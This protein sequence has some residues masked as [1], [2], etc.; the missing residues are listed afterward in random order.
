VGHD[1]IWEKKHRLSSHLKEVKLWKE[2]FGKFLLGKFSRKF[3]LH[4]YNISEDGLQ[5]G[6]FT[7]I[8]IL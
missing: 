1:G 5:I 3:S 6:K 8:R 7:F 2:S 4:A